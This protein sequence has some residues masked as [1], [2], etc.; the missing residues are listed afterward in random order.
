M[1]IEIDIIEKFSKEIDALYSE[2]AK[3]QKEYQVE[4]STLRAKIIN[5]LKNHIATLR[6]N[7]QYILQK[8]MDIQA[9]T[10]RYIGLMGGEDDEENKQDEVFLE[11]RQIQYS[12]NS[13]DNIGLI[14]KLKRLKTI[15]EYVLEKYQLRVNTIKD[16]YEKIEECKKHLGNK[17]INIESFNE[18]GEEII[19]IK[20]IQ[21]LTLYIKKFIDIKENR[22]II[23]CELRNKILNLWNEL[24]IEPQDEFDKLIENFNKNK[25]YVTEE[26]METI[27]LKCE[28]LEEEK[29]NR[30]L[31]V[32][33]LL[34]M[35]NVLW[36]KMQIGIEE[37][38]EIE[39]L[40]GYHCDTIKKYEN[41]LIRLN[42]MKKKYMKSFILKCK[43]ELETY[44]KKL[45]FSKEQQQQFYNQYPFID[46][47]ESNANSIE[48]EEYINNGENTHDNDNNKIEE[49]ISTMEI[50]QNPHLNETFNSQENKY[51]PQNE[52]KCEVEESK[53][54]NYVSSK[55]Y[56]DEAVLSAY[57][58][59]ILKMEKLYDEAKDVLELVGKHIKLVEEVKNF[60]IS[61]ADQTRLFQKGKRDPGR[62]L[63]EEKFRKRFTRERPKLEKELIKIL[64]DWEIQN[65]KPFTIYGKRYL[66][67]IKTL[68][69]EV[70]KLVMN[71]KEKHKSKSN[72]KNI[73]DKTINS[74]LNTPLKR[75]VQ[76]SQNKIKRQRTNNHEERNEKR[77][78]QKN[79][80][81][82]FIAKTPRKNI[83]SPNNW[84]NTNETPKTDRTLI[85][86]QKLLYTTSKIPN[87]PTQPLLSKN[88]PMSAR[89]TSRIPMLT[90]KNTY[91]KTNLF[92]VKL[93]QKRPFY[94]SDDDDNEEKR[95]IFE[96]FAKKSKDLNEILQKFKK[97]P[98]I[99]F[100]NK[101]STTNSSAVVSSSTTLADSKNSS[102]TISTDIIPNSNKD[103]CSN[104][105]P[106]STIEELSY[107]RGS[108]N[109]NTKIDK[110]NNHQSDAT[111]I[112]PF[113]VNNSYNKL[114]KDSIQIEIDEQLQSIHSIQSPTKSKIK[115]SNT[116]EPS[117][118]E[119]K[120]NLSREI[121]VK[122]AAPPQEKKVMDKSEG[123]TFQKFSHPLTMNNTL[124]NINTN[125]QINNKEYSN[126]YEIKSKILP[127]FSTT[128]ISISNSI[129][130][131]SSPFLSPKNPLTSSGM[132]ALPSSLKLNSTTTPQKNEKESEEEKKKTENG[133]ESLESKK[134]IKNEN[135]VITIATP[136]V[137][138]TKDGKEVIETYQYEKINLAEPSALTI[139]LKNSDSLGIGDLGD[140]SLSSINGEEDVDSFIDDIYF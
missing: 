126:N 9:E 42:K 66:D 1:I 111:I 39:N 33:L 121:N 130:K 99:D 74:E 10:Q 35:I 110:Q 76:K 82:D 132:V 41:E 116:M 50:N 136:V 101:T 7:K 23:A 102:N 107:I 86:T 78:I 13:S 27:R 94:F 68:D 20:R 18:N 62:L 29:S 138:T 51:H 123:E 135:N 105:N 140:K 64:S 60:E 119:E 118:Q 34:K 45:Y 24:G 87:T 38:K 83:P 133:Q 40:T 6:T 89:T 21:K 72:S 106:L 63:R 3:D 117:P 57:E 58:K 47:D 88:Y 81:N 43:L 28:K 122:K 52:E 44:W 70:S 112:T 31:K 73:S 139:K 11:L 59:E 97:T 134:K 108:S 114:K 53:N 85:D 113:R 120:E 2:L 19:S 115:P 65:N 22:L 79:E 32:E 8:I 12:L 90:L 67:S 71:E 25:F 103:V 55:S 84:K 75:I 30:K 96:N 14:P 80:N 100:N 36:D 131:E 56:S 125:T 95:E 4:I 91:K 98:S 48:S 49:I 109:S 16:I 77:Q 128:K 5:L 129:A 17:I 54:E 137:T 15:N 37:R 26:N 69:D 104:S 61:C 124:V 93:P 127:S 46:F 92:S